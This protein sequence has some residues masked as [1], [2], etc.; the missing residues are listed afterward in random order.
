M[1]KVFKSV[2]LVFLLTIL[3]ACT[4][5]VTNNVKPKN[6]PTVKDVRDLDVYRYVY[7]NMPSENY[8]TEYGVKKVYYEPRKPGEYKWLEK[9]QIESQKQSLLPKSGCVIDIQYGGKGSIVDNPKFGI[10]YNIV[11]GLTLFLIPY[12][13]PSTQ[14]LDATL[15]DAKTQKVLKKYHFQENVAYWVNSNPIFWIFYI[16]KGGSSE[17]S[18]AYSDLSKR[19]NEATAS[20]VTNDAHTLPE[21]QKQPQS[22]ANS[23]AKK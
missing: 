14:T 22:K 20:V 6:F 18:V 8:M 17:G 4:Y 15:I 3:N 1:N 16:G 10:P 5:T 2:L 19:L 23:A 21:C 12:Y 7:K 11:S 9:D 13:Q